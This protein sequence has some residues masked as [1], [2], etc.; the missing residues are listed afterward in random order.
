[1][2]I[3]KT[4]FT[5]G[6]FRVENNHKTVKTDLKS[7]CHKTTHIFKEKSRLETTH[8]KTITYQKLFINLTNQVYLFNLYLF[9]R[10]LTQIWLMFV[11]QVVL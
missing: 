3:F 5:N 4:N 8:E 11:W 6:K 10:I 9:L 7:F 2:K 1:M